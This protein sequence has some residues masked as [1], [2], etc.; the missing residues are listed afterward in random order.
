MKREQM[1]SEDP[2]FECPECGGDLAVGGHLPNCKKNR[3][4]IG[5]TGDPHFCLGAR[6]QLTGVCDHNRRLDVR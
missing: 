1:R 6:C 3:C 2:F 4:A 5:D